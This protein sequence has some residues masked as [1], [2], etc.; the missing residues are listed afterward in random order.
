MVELTSA[1]S[2]TCIA[3]VIRKNRNNA[4]KLVKETAV[5]VI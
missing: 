3:T 2:D 1:S 5:A 4:K